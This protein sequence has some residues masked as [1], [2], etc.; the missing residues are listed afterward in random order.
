V[1]VDI[2]PATMN[3]DPRL[4]R[5]RLQMLTASGEIA[6]TRAIMPVHTF[7]NP[8]GIGE[9][10]EIAAEFNVAIVEDAAC[11]LGATEDGRAAGS[12]GV[13]GCFSFHPRKIITTGEGGMLVTDDDQMADFARAFRNHGQQLVDGAVEFVM[14]GDNLRLTDIQGAIGVSQMARLPDLVES[15]TRL[16]ERY[17]RLLAP[18]GIEPQRRG[19]GAAVQSYVVLSPLGVPASHVISALRQ[20]GVEATVGTNAIPFTRYYAA[21]YGITEHDLPHTFAVSQRAVTLPL[22]PQMTE[23]EQDEVVQAVTEIVGVMAR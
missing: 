16:A 14:A 5:D 18:I 9:I 13:I 22:F 6:T 23:A 10:V 8:A 21:R 19:G 11:A 15:R 7:G 1:F 2:D 17:D 3:M 20:R 12:L 4:L